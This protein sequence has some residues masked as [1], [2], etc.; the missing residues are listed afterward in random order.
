MSLIPLASIDFFPVSLPSQLILLVFLILAVPDTLSPS[1]TFQRTSNPIP[2]TPHPSLLHVPSHRI[3]IPSRVIT[4]PY[5]GLLFPETLKNLHESDIISCDFSSD[6][7]D[8]GD[9][10]G[11]EEED[12]EERMITE[13]QP[14]FSFTDEPTSTRITREHAL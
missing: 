2:F 3:A 11:D 10:D 14:F 7:E 8:G 4:P 5:P 9:E 1:H 12:R 6:E 13:L